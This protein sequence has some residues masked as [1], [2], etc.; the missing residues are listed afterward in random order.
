MRLTAT[1]SDPLVP[2]RWSVALL[3]A[4]PAACNRAAAGERLEDALAAIGAPAHLPKPPL[5]LDDRFPAELF[6]AAMARL[7]RAAGTPGADR[8][9]LIDCWLA[10]RAA[11]AAW[12]QPSEEGAAP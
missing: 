7:E 12:P 6:H 2:L 8:D 1:E 9:A 11:G 3:H 4:R 5:V 10:L